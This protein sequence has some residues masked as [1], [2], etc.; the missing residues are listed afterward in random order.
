MAGGDV[1]PE[2]PIDAI[3]SG[4]AKDVDVL[5]GTTKHE[6]QLFAEMAKD[7]F[8]IT[9]ALLPMLYGVTFGTSDAGAAALE[10][11]TANRSGATAAALLSALQT[12]RMFRI[13]AVRLA[14]AQAAVGRPAWFYRFSWETPAFGGAVGAGHAIELPFTFDNLADP[15]GVGLTG[16]EGPQALADEVHGAWVRFI[17]DGDPG[18]A[19]YDPDTRTVRDFGGAD[20][21]V[22]DPEGDERVLWDGVL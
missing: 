5:I 13:P 21:L 22:L 11:Y 12:D 15:V 10:R 3:R 18:W 14:E 1:L 20:E 16:G 6:F 4:S 19:P 7:L 8:P 9:D 17:T 2:P